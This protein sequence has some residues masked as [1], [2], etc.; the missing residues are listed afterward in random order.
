MLSREAARWD[1]AV[2]GR[3]SHSHTRAPWPQ[4]PKLKAAA[5]R[6]NKGVEASARKLSAA[7]AKQQAEAKKLE[8]DLAKAKTKALAHLHRRLALAQGCGGS[9]SLGG[10]EGGLDAVRV[11]ALHLALPRRARLARWPPRATPQSSRSPCTPATPRPHP[12]HTPA[13]P[14]PCLGHPGS[15]SLIRPRDQAGGRCQG[16]GREG[17]RRVA[18]SRAA[19]GPRED[20]R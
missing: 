3:A 1:A 18:G 4:D 11:D 12:G 7:K 9:L 20:A 15:T 16:P 6:A 2:V 10:G 13:T 19:R 14:R 8:A 17:S 5:E